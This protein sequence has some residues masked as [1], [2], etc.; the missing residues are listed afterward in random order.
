MNHP[1]LPQRG[2][3]DMPARDILGLIIG[4]LVARGWITDRI[5][6]NT[7]T[8]MF[9]TVV[10]P[11]QADIWIAYSR[12]SGCYVLTGQYQSQGNNALSTCWAWIP[13]TA[14]ED[15]IAEAVDDYLARVDHAIDQTYAVRLLKHRTLR[16][17]V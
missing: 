12:E 3:S 7:V 1:P 2:S 15:E 16:P 10:A 8:K 4:C 13:A 11:K 5:V 6:R 17:G 14:G 9:M